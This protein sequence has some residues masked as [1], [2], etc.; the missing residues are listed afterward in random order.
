ML[1]IYLVQLISITIVYFYL[2][3]EYIPTDA[4]VS[5][6]PYWRVYGKSLAD[7]MV[8]RKANLLNLAA[9]LEILNLVLVLV[10]IIR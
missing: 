8:P 3:I 10:S 7:S 5:Q 6:N 4:T 2:V 1:I 9:H